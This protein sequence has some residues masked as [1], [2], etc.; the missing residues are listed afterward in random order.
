[1][2]VQI[3]HR[4]RCLLHC[5]VDTCTRMAGFA[6]STSRASGRSSASLCPSVR[7]LVTRLKSQA[8]ARAWI[9]SVRRSSVEDAGSPIPRAISSSMV[10]LM[11]STG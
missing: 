2:T 4:N 5:N 9:Y 10:A 6:D 8:S 3:Q 1:M 7:R 11:M